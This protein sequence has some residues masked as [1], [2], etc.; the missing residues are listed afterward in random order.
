MNKLLTYFKGIGVLE[1]MVALFPI[2]AGYDV[3][4]LIWCVLMIIYAFT[5][6][7]VAYFR[8]IILLLCFGYVL[9]HSIA[10]MLINNIDSTMF[11][12]IVGKTIYLFTII[13]VTR[14]VSYQKLL[15]S[16]LLVGVI[17]S[18]GL[19]YQLV[20]ILAGHTV[21]PIPLPFLPSPD[22][23]SRLYAEMGRPSSFFWEPASF[24]A[25]TMLL[26]FL[27]LVERKVALAVFFFLCILL[28]TSSN[29]IFMA[30]V[31]MAVYVLTSKAKVK[32]KF[33][34]LCGLIAVAI[35]FFQTNIFDIGKEKINNTDFSDNVRLANGPALV[36]QMPISDLVTGI[37]DTEVD[38]YLSS[39]SLQG[40]LSSSGGFFLSDFWY[41]L[42]VYG[43]VGL[44]LHLLVYFHLLKLDRTL[45]PYIV[46]LLIAQFTQS[47]SFRSM[48]VFQMICIWTYVLYN[49]K[50]QII[51]HV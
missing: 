50:Q 12:Q 10:V 21:S 51:N 25:F 1:L 24:V 6:K 49:K 45:L 38:K 47:V 35:V 33:W 23:D 43:I 20:L 37:T 44:I 15:P 39:Q 46:V 8:D 13:I 30:P 34:V 9:L 4:S 19:V 2:V 11:N 17:V 22:L 42:V 7:P 16:L 29:G 27:C 36:S 48:Y 26:L 28:S 5:R 40:M 18:I 32:N 31:M 41:V 14:Y 3:W